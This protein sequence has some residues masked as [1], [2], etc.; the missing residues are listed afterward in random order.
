[1]PHDGLPD[2]GCECEQKKTGQTRL[3]MNTSPKSAS[4]PQSVAKLKNVDKFPGVEFSTEIVDN[5][6]EKL[7]ITGG[8]VRV[9]KAFT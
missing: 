7:G 1:M 8:E 4:E 5:L 9:H 3:S 2:A 6:V